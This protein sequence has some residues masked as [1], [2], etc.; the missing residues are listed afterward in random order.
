MHPCNYTEH[1][2]YTTIMLN[3]GLEHTISLAMLLPQHQK[4][5]L[6]HVQ[7][8]HDLTDFTTVI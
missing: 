1:N 6:T 7:F 2:W 5:L 4:L 3:G 8:W